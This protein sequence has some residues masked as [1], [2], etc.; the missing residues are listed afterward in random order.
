MFLFTFFVSAGVLLEGVLS[1]WVSFVNLTEE[2]SMF[3]S[4]LN[5]LTFEIIALPERCF[6]A[7][8]FRGFISLCASTMQLSNNYPFVSK[9]NKLWI[10][11]EV[12]EETNY[13]NEM[14]WMHLQNKFD[15]FSNIWVE[16]LFQ[17][18]VQLFNRL[19]RL[20][21]TSAA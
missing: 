6:K 2:D 13:I 20:K 8:G 21:K 5:W 19:L 3:I 9:I 14:Y 1:I 16:Q 15:F 12:T 17:I 7:S 4:Y 10:K 18:F 11:L